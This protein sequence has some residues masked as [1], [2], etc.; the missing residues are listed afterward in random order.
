MNKLKNGCRVDFAVPGDHKVKIKESKNRDKYLDLAWELK[1]MLNIRMMEIL[2]V[3]SP[4][5]T[6]HNTELSRGDL[7]TLVIT[8]I[9]VK[10]HL[11]KLS[12][13]T[14]K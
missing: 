13:K 8:Q 10:V 4:F 9:P 5:E 7:N 1:K 2:I 6:V 11:L 12:W 3:V 14:Y